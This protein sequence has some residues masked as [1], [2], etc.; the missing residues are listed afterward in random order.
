MTPLAGVCKS[1]GLFS[2]EVLTVLLQRNANVRERDI[3]GETCLHHCFSRRGWF[4]GWITFG[5][6]ECL[7]RILGGVILLIEHGADVYAENDTGKSVSDLAYARHTYDGHEKKVGCVRGDVWDFALAM[8]GYS[9]LDFRQGRIRDARY[10]ASY[11]R[12]DFKKLWA[13]QEHLCPYYDAEESCH[14]DTDASLCT[15]KDSEDEWVTT[16]SEDET[17]GV[18]GLGEL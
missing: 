8:C 1:W 16:D 13:G 7:Q 6:S 4:N 2:R 18:D 5:K 15:N 10:G 12:Q 14:P 17:M 11:T 3:R 9:I